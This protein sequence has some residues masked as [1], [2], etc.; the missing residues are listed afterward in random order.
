MSRKRKRGRS[1]RRCLAEGCERFV[2][3]GEVVCR[4][5]A[6]TETG[7]RARAALRAIGDTLVAALE[8][9]EGNERR[10]R[11]EAFQRRLERGEYGVLFDERLRDVMAQAAEERG[12]VAEL[13]A[14]RVVLARLL[15]EEEDLGKLALGVSRIITAAARVERVRHAIGAEMEHPL[16]ARINDY[17]ASLGDEPEGWEGERERGGAHVAWAL[18]EGR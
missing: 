3:P 4:D 15:A 7:M 14:A 1:W 8:A 6:R 18:E 9:S 16:I 5:H 17:L 11:R 2:K 12:L 10:E 13:G